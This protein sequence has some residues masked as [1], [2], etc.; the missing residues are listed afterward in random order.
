[1][2]DQQQAMW[3]CALV[4]IL[5]CLSAGA[6]GAQTYPLPD[7]M[8]GVPYSIDFGQGLSELASELS[9]L[10]SGIEFSYSFAASGSLPPGLALT[11]SGLLSGTPT[12]PGPFTF[13]ISIT[14]NF[15]FDG[16]SQGGTFP[17]TLSINVQGNS[18]P[19]QPW[20]SGRT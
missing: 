15:S 13:T 9:T 18:G 12:A 2:I 1:M 8:V 11:A 17:Y 10:G 19:A 20:P 6:L 5:A 7:G 4:C 3:K 16:F 14:F